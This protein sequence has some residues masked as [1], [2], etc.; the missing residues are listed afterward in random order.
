MPPSM[1]IFSPDI[2]PNQAPGYSQI[3]K[4]APGKSEF[5]LKGTSIFKAY[6]CSKKQPTLHQLL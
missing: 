2:I 1:Q 3:K 5:Q 6:C 4:Q